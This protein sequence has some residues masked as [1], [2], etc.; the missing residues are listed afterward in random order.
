MGKGIHEMKIKNEHIKYFLESFG[1]I[2][3]EVITF[4]YF[5]TTGIYEVIYKNISGQDKLNID[6]K[7]LLPF[8]LD[9]FQPR[10]VSDNTYQNNK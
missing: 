4:E 8:Y 9:K 7:D 5:P 1:F 10:Q 3:Y 6:H 2:I